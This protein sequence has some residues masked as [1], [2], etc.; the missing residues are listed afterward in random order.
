[1]TKFRNHLDPSKGLVMNNKKQIDKKKRKII[2]E[3]KKVR[4]F[5]AELENVA[6][7]IQIS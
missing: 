7:N 6:L 2:L 3:I 4:I 1:M 5:T